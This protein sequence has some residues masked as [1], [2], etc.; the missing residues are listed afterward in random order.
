MPRELWLA[1]LE[2]PLYLKPGQVSAKVA[3]VEKAMFE[4]ARGVLRS[5]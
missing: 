4:R 3:E 1:E 2:S 5:G